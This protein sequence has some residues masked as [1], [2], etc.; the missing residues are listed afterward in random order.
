MKL[1][2]KTTRSFLFACLIAT[3]IGGILCYIFLRKVLDDEVTEQLLLQK[4]KIEKQVLRNGQLPDN[5]L[6]L[7]DSIWIQPASQPIPE[8]IKDTTFY[9]SAEHELLDCRQISFG[10]QTDKGYFKVNIRKTLYES[11]ELMIALFIVFTGVML[12]LVS[13]LFFVN[14]RVSRRIWQPF[15]ETLNLLQT[16]KITQKES[17][18]FHTTDIQEFQTLQKNLSALT[19]QVRREY[20][21]LKSFTEN[22]SHELQTPLAVIGSNLELLLQDNNL[23]EAQMQQ[24]GYL[25]EYLGKLSKL[26]QTLLLLTKIENRQFDT[27]QSIDFSACLQDKL[28]LL[29]VWIQHKN[30]QVNTSIQ[31][32]VTLQ[33]NEFLADVLL[34]NL[35]SNAIKYNLQEGEIV[36]ELTW[37]FLLI[38]NKG[39][40]PTIPTEQLFE[41]FKK[42]SAHAE[43]MGLGLALVKQ[44]CDTYHF[45]VTYLY[46]NGWHIVTVNF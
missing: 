30:L 9:A 40:R 4:M 5:F 27:A 19:E 34:N 16:F 25:I 36:I 46:K 38:K 13:M 8:L 33:I 37:N 3:V 28:N 42:D 43:S 29:D 22:A 24:M 39:V 12:L 11:D 2:N 20:Q 32:Q 35:L 41:R 1:I 6:S 18:A 31:P 45:E 23:T 26:N 7:I 10:I 17:L 15:Y 21:S 14:Y 44:I